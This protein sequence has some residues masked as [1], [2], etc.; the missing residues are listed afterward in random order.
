MSSSSYTV[1]V[2]GCGRSGTQYTAALLNRL[3]LAVGHESLGPDGVA[4]WCMAVDSSDAPWGSGRHGLSF[5]HV[6]H[7]V[8]HPLDVIPSLTTFAPA[9]WEFI[10]RFIPIDPE[11]PILRRAAKYWL[12]WNER[13]EKLAEWR[14]PIEEISEQFDAFCTRLGI[15]A[16][17]EAIDH[18]S[19]MTNSRRFRPVM[20]F[21]GKLFSK[22]HFQPTARAFDFLYDRSSSY[23]RRPLTWEELESAA[24]G[25]SRRVHEL[26]DHYGYREH[27]P[28][29]ERV[30]HHAV[31][32]F[33]MRNAHGAA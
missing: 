4:S 30:Q 25:W 11:E 17:R 26:A 29:R 15:P 24:P 20:R 18:T 10:A 16:R 13:A 33:R 28:S 21:V 12:F 22:I 23:L 14:Y 27:A 5:A 1:L 19:R 3:G 6:F 31:Q 9:S 8:R 7:Q 32:P 2:T